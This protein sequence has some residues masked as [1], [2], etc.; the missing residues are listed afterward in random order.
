MYFYYKLLKKVGTTMVSNLVFAV[1]GRPSSKIFSEIAA[2][3]C[4]DPH[5]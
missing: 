3:L 1:E 4:N 2:K 5:E